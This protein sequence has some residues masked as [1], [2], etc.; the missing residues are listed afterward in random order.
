MHYLR[1]HAEQEARKVQGRQAGQAAGR[2]TKDTFAKHRLWPG[3]RWYLA[4]ELRILI[5]KKGEQ[6]RVMT[7]MAGANTSPA[8][9]RETR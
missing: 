9:E 2:Q 3:R 8:G 6:T 7:K 1:T 5:G 4:L